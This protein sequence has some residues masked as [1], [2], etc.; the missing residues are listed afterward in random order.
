MERQIDAEVTYN[1][2]FPHKNLHWKGFCVA[3]ND[4]Q[5]GYM[6]LL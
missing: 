5:N 1:R 2:L 3:F 6:N 4:T